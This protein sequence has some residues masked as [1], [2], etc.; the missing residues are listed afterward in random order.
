MSQEMVAGAPNASNAS[1]A[2]TGPTPPSSPLVFP[3]H[4]RPP[5]APYIPGSSP[6]GFRVLP[7]LTLTYA[8]S[9]DSS[10]SL[11]PGTQ[12]LLSGPQS[13][14]MTH[15]LRARH[16]AIL[17]GAGTAIADD[18]G[19]NCRL[20]GAAHQ[21]RPVVLDHAARWDVQESAR[22]LH[23]ARLGEGKGVWVLVAEG[24]PYPA[25]RRQ[26]IE[27]GGGKIIHL[28][29]AG[30][31]Q[32]RFK[33]T[34][35]LVTLGAQGI[36]TVMVEGGGAVINDLLRPGND[37]HITSV[38]ITIAPTYLGK[39]GVV[40]SPDQRR[41]T[42]PEGRRVAATTFVDVSWAVMGSDAVF[43]GRINPTVSTAGK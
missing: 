28:P 5:I 21:P 4:L 11:S 35:I 3:E 43:C 25:R 1:K 18:P 39:G 33:W 9:L 15:F 40:V 37:A 29:S 6:P 24:T 32:R 13:K 16:D 27:E 2:P 17:V 34:D 30:D 10:L 31:G 19:L 12:T 23:T 38:I 41:E 42:Q 7:H 26:V 8:A 20:E 36:H 22:V 14:A